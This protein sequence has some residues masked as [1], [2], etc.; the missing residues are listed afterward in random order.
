M[1]DD[2]IQVLHDRETIRDLFY[3]F[4]EALDNRDWALL[5]SL[6][7]SEVD[8]DFTAWGIPAGKIAQEQF[9]AL[10]RAS[11]WRP[12]L[13]TQH[14]Y[15]NFRID[16]QGDIAQVTFNFLGQHYTPH[17]SDG[18]E[19]F[20]RGEYSDT[21]LRSETGWKITGVRLRVFYTSGAGSML[22]PQ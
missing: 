9:V 22:T 18:E 6:C 3:R 2:R 20:L 17:F 13:I 12:E 7:H 15:T 11:F 1:T 16:V 14:L 19:F 10:F 8:A 5:T 21:L 4:A